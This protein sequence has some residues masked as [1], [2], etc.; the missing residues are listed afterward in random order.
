MALL[1]TS[2]LGAGDIGTAPTPPEPPFTWTDGL[3]FRFD[4]GDGV[5]GADGVTPAADGDPVA[6][7]RNLGTG[8]DAVQGD[9]ARRP[10]FR[11]G[12]SAGR[13]YIACHHDQNQHFEDLA[14]A[15]PAGFLSLAPFTVFA[16][17]DAV[18][19]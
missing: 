9:P 5:F 2:L 4:A 15:Q 3:A 7:W 14:F 18:G 13:P 10:V 6:R 11:S 17:T 1:F 12:G 8:A 16:V 19:A